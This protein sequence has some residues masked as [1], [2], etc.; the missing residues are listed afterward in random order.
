MKPQDIF[1]ANIKD[2][3]IASAAITKIPASFTI[4]EAA[5]ESA[6]GTSLLATNGKNLFGVKADSSW[7]G[8]TMSIRTREWFTGRWESVDALWRK[9]PD[10]AGSIADHAKFLM[11][12]K[13]YAP[14]F[15]TTNVADFTAAVHKAG[16]ATD[17]TYTQKIMSVIRSNHLEVLDNVSKIG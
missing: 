14:A 3:A 8:N 1:I 15:L 9:Y 7:T 2:A 12:N 10:W 11:T 4:A 5:L 6:W 16:Y 13:R 17:P